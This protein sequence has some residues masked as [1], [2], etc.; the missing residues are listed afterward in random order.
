MNDIYDPISN[1]G[2]FSSFC[3]HIDYLKNDINDYKHYRMITVYVRTDSDILKIINRNKK[4]SFNLRNLENTSHIPKYSIKKGDFVSFIEKNKQLLCVY[5][6]PYENDEWKALVSYK[7][8]HWY[9]WNV[10]TNE[11]TW[12]CPKYSNNK[13]VL[14]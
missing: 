1:L 3:E 2:K 6:K 14:I 9:W 11:T 8:N 10:K 4:Y 7:Y 5:P 13:D 12:R